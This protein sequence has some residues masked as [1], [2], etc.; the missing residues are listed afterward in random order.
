MSMKKV[1]S[2]IIVLLF[3]KAVLA[4]EPKVIFHLQSADTL[5]YKSVVSQVSNLKKEFPLAGIEV[6]CHGPGIDFL[7]DKKTR[8][9]SRLVAMGFS[10]VNLV[11]CEFT[12]SQR[13]IKKDDLLPAV[14]TVPFGIA[15]IVRK[16]RA[17][18]IYIKAGF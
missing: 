12:M 7:R 8:Y 18:W 16:Q 2:L 3:F 6:L 14:S 4:Q 10:D 13:K 17:G 15:E 9:A 1:G 5:V 11:A